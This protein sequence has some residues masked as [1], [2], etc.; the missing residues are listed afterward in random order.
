M[1][2]YAICRIPVLIPTLLAVSLAVFPVLLRAPGNLARRQPATVELAGVAMPLTMLVGI[3]SGRQQRGRSR[4]EP[5]PLDR[6]L[7]ES[8]PPQSAADRRDAE[9]HPNH[10]AFAFEIPLFNQMTKAQRRL[11]LGRER[12]RPRG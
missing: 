10:A 6:D 11:R 9:R 7:A 1:L 5:G 3:H 2:D 8:L 4:G 12:C